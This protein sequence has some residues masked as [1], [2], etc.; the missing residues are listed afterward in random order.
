MSESLYTDN[1]NMVCDDCGT[2][3]DQEDIHWNDE[4]TGECPVCFSESIH[5]E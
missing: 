1:P 3:F 5:G 4:F 2:H